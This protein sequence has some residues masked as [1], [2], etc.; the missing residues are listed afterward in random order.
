L[1]ETAGIGQAGEE[2]EIRLTLGAVLKARRGARPQKRRQEENADGQEAAIE[3]QT[4]SEVAVSVTGGVEPE[5][6]GRIPHGT[7]TGTLRPARLTRSRMPSGTRCSSSTSGNAANGYALRRR[8]N[9]RDPQQD[10]LKSNTA[11]QSAKQVSEKVPAVPGCRKTPTGDS[12]ETELLPERRP[13]MIHR[14][15]GASEDNP[16]HSDPDGKQ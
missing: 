1:P 2:M 5:L 8:A 13:A 14:V 4:R 10:G 15:T 9:G 3:R 12:S 11:D 6:H 7:R 16:R